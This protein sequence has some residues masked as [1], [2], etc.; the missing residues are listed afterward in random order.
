LFE[1]RNKFRGENKELVK[2]AE[3][4]RMEQGRKT[5]EEFMQEF[6][7]VVRKSKCKGRALIKKFKRGI[8]E[9]II[10]KLMKVERLSTSIEQ[11]YE[12]AINLDRY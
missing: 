2:V 5:M 7:R 6:R 4:K 9:V 8:N 3:L 1:L 10:R 12:Q 11:W